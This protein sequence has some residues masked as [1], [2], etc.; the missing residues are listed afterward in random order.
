MAADVSYA[1]KKAMDGNTA[2][3]ALTAVLNVKLES[4]STDALEK[5]G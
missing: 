5:V 4:A 1:L 3:N 2:E